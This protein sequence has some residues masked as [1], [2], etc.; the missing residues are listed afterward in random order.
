MENVRDFRGIHLNVGEIPDLALVEL[1]LFSRIVEF[2]KI[3]PV[4]WD[5]LLPPVVLYSLLYRRFS[6]LRDL[7][8]L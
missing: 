2:T 7:K 5:R 3:G 8:L 1:E 4:L 6:V